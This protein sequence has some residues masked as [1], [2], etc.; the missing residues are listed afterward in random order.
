[1]SPHI[2]INRCEPKTGEINLKK[3]EN[4]QTGF[5]ARVNIKILLKG[6][7]ITLC[8]LANLE[9]SDRDYCPFKNKK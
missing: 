8:R 4:L 5:F 9:N 1:M 6:L 2:L 7:F 3:N